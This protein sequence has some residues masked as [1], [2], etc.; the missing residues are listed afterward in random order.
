MDFF[1]LLTMIGGLALFLYGMKTMGDS[2]SKMAGGRLEQILE[3]M[4]NNPVKAV[5]LGAGVT[6]VIQSSSATTVMVVGFVNSG[7]M[8]LSQAVGVIMGANIGTTATSWILSL[9]GIESGNFFVKL[10]KPSS[11]SP[12]LAL[13]GVVLV[14][15]IKNTK[16]NDVG[17]ILIGFAVL[18][19]GMDTMSSA[20]K[21]LADVPE[22]TS[23]FTAFE[24]PFLGM[25]VGTI[26]TAVIQSSSAS[27]GILQAM[28]ATGSVSVGAALPVIMGQN[29]GTCVTALLSGVGAN[30]NARRASLVHLYFNLVGTFVFMAIF[31][32]MDHF[33]QFDFMSDTANGA[34]IAMIHSVFNIVST[35]VLL[36]AS[37]L[38]VKLAYF[39]IPQSE[40]ETLETSGKVLDERFLERPAFA[41]AQCKNAVYD[42]AQLILKA[43]N[44]CVFIQEKYDENAVQEIMEIEQEVDAM[45]DELSSYLAKLSTKP[46]SERDSKSINKYSRCIMDFERISD[47]TKGIAFAQKKLYK[48]KEKFSKKAAAEARLIYE[49]TLEIVECMVSGFIHEDK[50]IAFRIDALADVI[51][52]VK[53]E[54]QKNHKR[55]L[56]KG[57]C[58]VELGMAL[59]DMVTSLE[60]IA[61]HCSNIAEEQMASET[62]QHALHQNARNVKERNE[63]YREL[64]EGY[65]EKYSLEKLEET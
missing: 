7:I 33:V 41:V 37:R 64:L 35:I 25:I 36:P 13:I 24:N 16:K 43:M 20:V 61:K 55:R 22:F 38:L 45:E 51:S 5:L 34:V 57:K 17:T 54:I 27:V 4:T 62:D 6:A 58:S 59:T 40:D 47:Y 9:S 14:M 26:L 12:V 65:T 18:M 60:R 63:L 10:L 31:Y 15:F 48:G 39:T 52:R 21:P 49:A 23:L 19:F 30:K 50:E 53:K 1:G 42:M 56:E 29:I 2:L 32:A 3:R 11:F 46:L 28:C 44:L 8:K